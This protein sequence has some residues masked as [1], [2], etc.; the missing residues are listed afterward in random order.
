MPN[1]LRKPLVELIED[2]NV[3]E[4]LQWVY[5]YLSQIPLLGGQFTHFIVKFSAAVANEKIP[6]KLGF[7]PT[8]V[9]Q[10]SIIGPGGVTATFGYAQFDKTN[11]VITT[12]GA[13]VIRFFAG[14]YE[15]E[16]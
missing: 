9:I 16:L 15:N 11:L 12:S 6:H 3:R 5:E 10:T 14:R 1:N 2:E 13:C 7:T 8:D 4:S